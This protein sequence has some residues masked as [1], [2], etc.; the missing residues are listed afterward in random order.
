MKIQWKRILLISVSYILVA[1]VASACTL[2][3]WDAK[4]NKLAELESIIENKFIG[5]ADMEEARD[6]AA[7]AMVDAIGD[8]WSYYI[9]AKDYA[10]HL[11]NKNNA[12]VGVGITI[13]RQEEGN[14]YDILEVSPG[15]SAQEGGILPGD[16][17]IE[18][19]GQSTSEMT[20]EEVKRVVRGEIGAEV[21]LTVLRGEELLSF[22]LERREIRVEVAKGQMLSGNVGY[23]K[24]ANFN[25]N[26]ADETIE[27]VEALLE[28]GAQGLIFDVRNNPGG[29]VDEML[30]VLDYLL[31]KGVLYRDLD[32][33]GNEGE[34]RSDASC[35]ELPMAVLVNED[36]Y[37]A[38]E[39]FAAAMQE[40]EWAT[41]VGQH[42]TG[43]GHYQNTLRLSDGSAVNLSTGKYFTPSGKNLTE[44]G[45]IAPDIVEE[46][47]E[48]TASLIYSE[49]LEPEKD[50]QIQAAL[51]AVMGMVE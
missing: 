8:R 21:T 50:P 31:P 29:Y 48:E 44:T 30:E 19:E 33:L 47:D 39:F 22:T 23:V 17:L 42:T 20:M 28:Q 46:V 35:L 5:D 34:E 9:S 14:G 51:S 10:A 37:S 43:K 40:F 49:A 6:A 1:A 38:A 4:N 32:Y 27:A 11:E 16:L 15:G 25:T 18:V 36:S 26:C 12:F 24:I 7:A 3:L 45:G 41:I 2:F 13:S